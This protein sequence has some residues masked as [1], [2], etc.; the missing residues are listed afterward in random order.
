MMNK[1]D[2]RRSGAGR[3][4]LTAA[5]KGLKTNEEIVK[6]LEEVR[7]TWADAENRIETGATS[8][9]LRQGFLDDYELYCAATF[10]ADEAWGADGELFL[11][12]SGYLKVRDVSL[13]KRSSFEFSVEIKVK[14]FKG[15]S[16]PTKRAHKQEWV[17]HPV[18]KVSDTLIP[19]DVAVLSS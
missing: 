12:L 1:D 18:T 9:R 4:S 3:A 13:I 14:N 5:L 10:P 16:S 17:F 19:V 11:R 8:W 15:F 6:H 7:K 2:L